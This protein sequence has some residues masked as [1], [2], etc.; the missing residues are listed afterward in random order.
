MKMEK[1]SGR[2][3]ER[4]EEDNTIKEF[5]SEVAKVMPVEIFCSIAEKTFPNVEWIEKI[6]HAPITRNRLL[7]ELNWGLA[8]IQYIRDENPELPM[9][10]E[11]KPWM[12]FF[13]GGGRQEYDEIEFTDEEYEILMSLRPVNV[14]KFIDYLLDVVRGYQFVTAEQR[15]D[16]EK[17]KADG[18]RLKEV[19]RQT[20]AMCMVA[21]EQNGFALQY[22]QRP[23]RRVFEEAKKQIEESVSKKIAELGSE[24]FGVNFKTDQEYLESVKLSGFAL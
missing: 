16:F 14:D 19:E 10:R 11:Y 22:V 17:V 1:G 8:R 6:Y 4:K 21:V 12:G 23:T 13:C 2:T 3:L 20:Y 15:A 7:A 18:M 5:L 9:A 24:D